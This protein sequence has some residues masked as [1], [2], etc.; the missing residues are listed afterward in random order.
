MRATTAARMPA[1]LCSIAGPF[2]WSRRR[3]SR[4]WLPLGK[5]ARQHLSTAPWRLV[6]CRPKRL[7]LRSLPRSPA[8]A[9]RAGLRVKRGVALYCNSVR[10][11]RDYCVM[12]ATGK[13]SRR[14]VPTARP[15]LRRLRKFR[16]GRVAPCR[17]KVTVTQSPATSLAARSGAVWLASTHRGG[18]LHLLVSWSRSRS[19]KRTTRNLMIQSADG[20]LSGGLVTLVCACR[21]AQLGGADRSAIVPLSF[22]SGV[23]LFPYSQRHHWDRHSARSVVLSRTFQVAG[24]HSPE[25]PRSCADLGRLDAWA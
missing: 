23:D 20:P 10:R 4:N 5:L 19:H 12:L 3:A 15:S 13:P 16:A 17:F 14:A 8:L 1:T 9:D 25:R 24:N 21:H 18:K 11:F 2:T 6:H 22:G 7:A